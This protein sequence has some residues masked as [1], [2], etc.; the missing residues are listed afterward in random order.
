MPFPYGLSFL[1]LTKEVDCEVCDMVSYADAMEKKGIEKGLEI[2]HNREFEKSL[3]AV[4][5]GLKDYVSDFDTLYEA[6]MKN[7]YYSKATKEQIKKYYEEAC[8]DI[9]DDK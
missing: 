3:K 4:V 5:H 7:E 1:K 6:V 2:A 9:H 8:G